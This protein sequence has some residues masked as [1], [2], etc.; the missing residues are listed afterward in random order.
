MK[1]LE[2]SPDFTIDDIHKIREFD[3][4]RRRIIGDEAY[5]AEVRSDALYMQEKIKEAR[6][7]RLTHEKTNIEKAM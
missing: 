7:M 1:E 5:W 4:E 6:E 2:I 3:V